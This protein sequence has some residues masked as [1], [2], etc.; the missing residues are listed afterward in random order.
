MRILI[1][2]SKAK[3]AK[4]LKNCL[5]QFGYA[6]DSSCDGKKGLY[7]AS[8]YDYDLILLSLKLP[9]VSGEEICK[10]LREEGRNNPIII[11]S[12]QSGTKTKI[13]LLELGADDYITKPYSL[14]EL[15]A[16]VRAVMRRPYKLNT[17]IQE[18]GKFTVDIKGRT[19][20]KGDKEIKLTK[21]EF[22]LLEFLIFN[23]NEVVSRGYIMEHVW[24]MNADPFSNTIE[25]HILNLRK[26]LGDHKKKEI[27]VT[28]PGIGYKI[29]CD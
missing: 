14:S 16:R 10:R 24:D 27:I 29:C 13:K 25:T 26:K 6:V 11:L 9:N 20:H 1:I 21:K 5:Q 2:N 12:S 17:T 23:K 18:I 19:L 3:V 28:I 22:S 15:S 4:Y 7:N 8:I